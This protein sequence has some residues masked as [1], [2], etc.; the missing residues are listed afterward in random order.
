MVEIRITRTDISISACKE[1]GN[2]RA[3]NRSKVETGFIHCPVCGKHTQQIDL[4]LGR[5]VEVPT[6]DA[7][8]KEK[9]RKYAFPY[10]RSEPKEAED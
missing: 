1:C 5:I 8:T 6:S 3:W 9:V 10:Y 4:D 7:D 2:V